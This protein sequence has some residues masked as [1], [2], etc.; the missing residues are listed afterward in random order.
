MGS[1][2]YVIR[3]MSGTLL[4]PMLIHGLWDSSLFLNVATG[5]VPSMVQFAV[6]PLAIVCAIAVVKKNWNA[7]VS[8]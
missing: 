4:L 8:S 7:R 2:F 3:R 5:G 1:G 6:Y